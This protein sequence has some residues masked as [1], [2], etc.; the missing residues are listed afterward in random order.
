M[1]ALDEV[2]VPVQTNS[3]GVEQTLAVQTGADVLSHDP[4]VQVLTADP[5]APT[6]EQV[7]VHTDP[8]AV[9]SLAQE[10]VYTDA[11]E[12]PAAIA[13]HG[14]AAHDPVKVH[15]PSLDSQT[16]TEGEPV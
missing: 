3:A 2:A 6:A 14:F 10:L 16:G 9:V 8:E 12:P 5:L 1:P 4:A 13:A 15:S 11:P 7:S